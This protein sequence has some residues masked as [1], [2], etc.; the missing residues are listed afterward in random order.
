MK[1]V[2]R[3]IIRKFLGTFLFALALILTIAVVFDFSEKIDDFMDRE[4]PVRAIIFDYYLNFVPYFGILFSPL[5]VFIAVIFFTAK[6]AANSEIVAILNS[7]MSFRRMMW[8]YF[9]SS[10]AIALF[11]FM[12]T[13]FFIPQS[14]QKRLDFE[15]KYYRPRYR[16]TQM[17]MVHRQ[18]YPNIYIYMESYNPVTRSG[19][20]FTIESFS[21]QGQLKSK[22]SSDVVRWDTVSG[23]WSAWNY[24]IRDIG[25]SLE[26]ISTG[27]RIDTTLTV[28]PDDFARSAE[29]VGTMT[30]RELFDYIDLLKLQGSEEIKFFQIEKHRRFAMPFS[31]FILTLIG[32][33]LS[34]KKVR[35]GIGMKIGIGLMLSFSYILFMQL[36]S[37]FSV[38]GNL[39]PMLA[40][41]LPNIM[42]AAI[43]VFLYRIAPK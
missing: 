3:Y 5:F 15:D 4:A 19:R 39:D 27:R 6:M 25:D 21:D 17:M 31:V 36:S 1:I 13:N 20:N 9:L 41:W 10:F 12:V 37:Q 28:K 32:V 34:S 43:G 40:M 14:N 35:G 29:F 38:K 11:T 16:N 7:G 30:Y 8:P 22:L 26:V 18:V 42:Y 2:D 33:S 23:K 24:N